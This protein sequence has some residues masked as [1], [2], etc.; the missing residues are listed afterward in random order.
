MKISDRFCMSRSQ[1]RDRAGS[2]S[3]KDKVSRSAFPVICSLG[4]VLLALLPIPGNTIL[5]GGAVIAASFLHD[6]P[7]LLDPVVFP[8]LK[9]LYSPAIPLRLNIHLLNGHAL[10]EDAPRGI[11]DE[12][13]NNSWLNADLQLLESS[14]SI[15]QWLRDSPPQDLSAF[16]NFYQAYYDGKKKITSGPIRAALSHIFPMDKK[17]T[18]PFDLLAFI[19]DLSPMEL[20]SI[21]RK[22]IFYNKPLNGVEVDQEIEEVEIPL[23]SLQIKGTA[24]HLEKMLHA[25]QNER[26]IGLKRVDVGLDGKTRI[27]RA[28]RIERRFVEAPPELWFH[29]VRFE[30]V[31]Q[32]SIFNEVLF[33]KSIFPPIQMGMSKNIAPVWIP[34]EIEIH[35]LAGPSRIYRLNAFLVHEGASPQENRVKVYR[36][37]N[38]LLYGCHNERIVKVSHLAEQEILSQAYL[39]HYEPV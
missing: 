17:G 11:K 25:F 4:I 22:T 14:S 28:K 1:E 34:R 16:R 38:H 35:P 19:L 39:L 3:S 30:N 13:G 5:L 21:V 6:E 31:V 10:P 20:K 23:L 9:P 7:P 12:N 18:D 15:M 2:S 8:K 29:I 32:K 24:P 36:Y 33:L 27:Y 26:P 37:K